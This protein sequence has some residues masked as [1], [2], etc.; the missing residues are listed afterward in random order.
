MI[1][2]VKALE[3]AL[4]RNPRVEGVITIDFWLQALCVFYIDTQSLYIFIF[5]ENM[6]IKNYYGTS[7]ICS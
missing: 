6:I 2:Y 4:L 1:V 3:V 5:D 7:M